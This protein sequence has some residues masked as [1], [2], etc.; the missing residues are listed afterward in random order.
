VGTRMLSPGER[1]VRAGKAA[2]TGDMPATGTARCWTRRAA[3][4]NL[5]P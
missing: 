1:L 2:R 3:A 4:G 5:R